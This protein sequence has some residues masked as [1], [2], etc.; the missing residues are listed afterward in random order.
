MT[1][2]LSQQPSKHCAADAQRAARVTMVAE[3]SAR[4]PG[5]FEVRSQQILSLAKHVTIIAS[6][7][8]ECKV[9]CKCAYL[10]G[11]ARGRGASVTQVLIPPESPVEVL[12]TG[13][14]QLI[15]FQIAATCDIIGDLSQ[16]CP[17]TWSVDDIENLWTGRGL[18]IVRDSE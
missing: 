9:M 11:K 17:E 3:K 12:H 4:K 15:R 7:S 13:C 2:T 14:I 1:R 5:G 8:S 18:R 6:T 10:H 16:P